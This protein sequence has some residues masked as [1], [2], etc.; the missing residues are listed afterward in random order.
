MEN[1]T[2]YQDAFPEVELDFEDLQFDDST[3]S[4]TQLAMD[5]DLKDIG[6]LWATSVQVSNKTFTDVYKQEENADSS[7]NSE[8]SALHNL[9]DVKTGSTV[10]LP[11]GVSYEQVLKKTIMETQQLSQTCEEYTVEEEN[12]KGDSETGVLADVNTQ[13]EER[14]REEETIKLQFESPEGLDISSAEYPPFMEQTSHP[15]SSGTRMIQKRSSVSDESVSC[16]A[17]DQTS[18]CKSDGN[19]DELFVAG[20]HVRYDLREFTEEDQ[21]QVEESLAEYPSDLS[22]SESET[23]AESGRNKLVIPLDSSFCYDHSAHEIK[24]SSGAEGNFQERE[25]KTDCSATDSN[26]KINKLGIDY[27]SDIADI[28]VSLQTVNANEDDLQG[29]LTKD[30]ITVE[31]TK[32]KEDSGDERD[33]NDQPGYDSDISNDDNSTSQEETSFLP[34]EKDKWKNVTQ[35]NFTDDTVRADSIN[36]KETDKDGTNDSNLEKSIHSA[37][38]LTFNVSISEGKET[39]STSKTSLSYGEYCHKESNEQS[40]ELHSKLEIVQLGSAI[41]EQVQSPSEVTDSIR[42]TNTLI[43]EAFW[44]SVLMDDDSLC[45]DDYNWNLTE[46]ELSEAEKQEAIEETL[47]KM[48]HSEDGEENES[49]WEKKTRI[50]AFNQFYGDQTETWGEIGRNHRVTFCLDH[51][52]SEYEEDSESTEEEQDKEPHAAVTTVKPEYHSESDEPEEKLFHPEK[53]KT[54]PKEQQHVSP[55]LKTHPQRNRCLAVLKSALA[56]GLMTAVGVLS[57]WWAT[58]SLDQTH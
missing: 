12:R 15:V 51:E 49:D 29:I 53:P 1:I 54:R 4:Q 48:D 40:T 35:H 18:H 14:F 58:D 5:D 56:L 17:E 25:R 23:C 47:G 16:S 46:G 30:Y 19:K 41:K 6:N 24:D 34:S 9:P 20:C 26:S 3:K 57:F 42:D 10:Y 38:H 37:E 36:Y 31:D 7:D 11:S 21:E 50:E 39:T 28:N 43:P 2:N 52:P 8:E 27:I 13:R 32:N 45:L 22:Q 55:A 44:S 33:V